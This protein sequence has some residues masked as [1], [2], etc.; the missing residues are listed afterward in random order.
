MS[1]GRT[2]RKSNVPTSMELAKGVEYWKT[3]M[4]RAH[5]GLRNALNSRQREYYMNR[6]DRA[7]IAIWTLEKD[8]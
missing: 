8:A 5:E 3:Q 2:L 7:G 6:I 4:S 1:F